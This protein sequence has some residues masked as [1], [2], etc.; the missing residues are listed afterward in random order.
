[1]ARA[2]EKHTEMLREATKAKARGV[3]HGSSLGKTRWVVERTFVWLHPFKR[4]RIRYEIR[5]DLHHGLLQ[6]ACIIVYLR[7]LRTSF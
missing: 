1:M 5:A 7:R 2:E 3:A 4:L 6:P